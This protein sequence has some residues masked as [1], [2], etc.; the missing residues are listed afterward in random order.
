[1]P[2]TSEF[3]PEAQQHIDDVLAKRVWADQVQINADDERRCQLKAARREK[4][5]IRS[6]AWRLLQIE[7]KK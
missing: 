6:A 7:P 3:S 5:R 2:K 4:S 1:M